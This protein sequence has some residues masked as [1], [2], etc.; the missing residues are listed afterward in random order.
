MESNRETGRAEHEFSA[1]NHQQRY[2]KTTKGR[3]KCQSIRRPLLQSKVPSITS[4][5]QFQS[6]MPSTSCPPCRK[7]LNAGGF[8]G[9]V[10]YGGSKRG[11][12]GGATGDVYM[13]F[14]KYFG[15]KCWNFKCLKFDD[16]NANNAETKAKR[17]LEFISSLLNENKS[18]Q[19]KLFERDEFGS[20]PI[21]FLIWVIQGIHSNL[22]HRGISCLYHSVRRI[23][24]C[25][26]LLPICTYVCMTCSVCARIKPP[27]GAH[28]VDSSLRSS[29]ANDVVHV[30]TLDLGVNARGTNY[31]YLQVR[32]DGWL[33]RIDAS[34]LKA[35]DD[36]ASRDVFIRD[37]IN[38]YG[39]CRT[40]QTD[41]GTEF[42]GTFDNMLRS[43]NIKHH[44]T[45]VGSSHSHGIAE[46]ANREILQALRAELMERGLEDC[47]WHLVL[48]FVLSK[49]KLSCTS[50]GG[51]SVF[52]KVNGS[53]PM[54]NCASI[55]YSFFDA[56]PNNND[57]DN[58]I[59]YEV[60]E[61][62]LFFHP[63]WQFGHANSRGMKLNGVWE[64]M[65]IERKLSRH[66][67][68]I[69]AHP[70]NAFRLPSYR[71]VVRV[72]QLRKYVDNNLNPIANPPPLAQPI[73][74]NNPNIDGFSVGSLVIFKHDVNES[75]RIGKLISVDRTNKMCNVHLFG[76]YLKGKGK[77]INKC[78]YPAWCHP[79]D[80]S[81]CIFKNESPPSFVPFM[82]SISINDIL[83]HGFTLLPNGKL[84]RGLVNRYMHG[85]EG[86]SFFASPFSI[87][88]LEGEEWIDAEVN[89]HKVEKEMFNENNLHADRI[90]TDVRNSCLSA[91][92]G[93]TSVFTPRMMDEDDKV[94]FNKAIENEFKSFEEKKVYRRL[95]LDSVDMNSIKPIR[96]KWVFTRKVLNVNNKLNKIEYKYKARLTARGDMDKREDVDSS[97]A[98]PPISSL[99][100]I[101][102]YATSCLV[103]FSP[104]DL[105]QA[106]VNTAYLNASLD[107]PTPVYVW[108]PREHPDYGKYVWILD[109]AMYGMREAG[110]KWFNHLWLN[111]LRPVG[112]E[113]TIFDGLYVRYTEDRKIDGV[114]FAWVDDLFAVSGRTKSIDLL[115]EIGKFVD[116]K[117]NGIPRNFIGLNIDVSKSR[118]LLSQRD[119]CKRIPVFEYKCH[120]IP[121]SPLPRNIHLDGNKD[122]PLLDDEY[123]F[124]YRSLWGTV[125]FLQHSRPDLNYCISFFGRFISK[126]TQYAWR[127]LLR[128]AYYCKHTCNICIE[129]KVKFTECLYI[130]A[131]CDA[132]FGSSDHA[133]A[134]T[135][136]LI[137]VNKSPVIFKSGLQRRVATSTVKAELSALHDCCDLLLLLIYFFSQLNVNVRVNLYSDAKNL[138]SLL[139]AAHP[140]PAEKYLLI[141]LR[142][143]QEILDGPKGNRIPRLKNRSEKRLEKELN[144]SVIHTLAL[145]DMFTYLPDY[146]I[147][148]DHI[149]GTINP[150][151][152]LTKSV[153]PS[154]MLDNFLVSAGM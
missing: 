107:S 103:D 1:T 33:S 98:T 148:L 118:V 11:K 5:N 133:H 131:Y 7:R 88:C 23:L 28:R 97:S 21:S 54:F 24:Y 8:T 152:V 99:R 75:L 122:S 111:V 72:N 90:Y 34:I 149:S 126:P 108:P 143:I 52:E 20:A 129:F 113:M 144:D 105:Q 130:D 14:D 48:P 59:S 104:D 76:A 94:G 151:D 127:L 121:D 51:P 132:S 139:K 6:P 57:S 154:V 92:V 95:P 55:L 4:P 9:C 19:F 26:Y 15:S 44:V 78:F 17:Y 46:R 18:L 74:M 29:A 64:D 41:G 22:A 146:N 56:I 84:P 73:N 25:D 60:G 70:C 102:S 80:S 140:K 120:K 138:V 35:H 71:V 32:T 43:F 119:Y 40:C 153:D 147:N 115:R 125:A 110:N 142:K 65:I 89:F 39:T 27:F 62:V 112:Y 61:R 50:V 36:D 53:P 117:Y 91:I 45:P 77:L 101:I 66:V 68:V 106:D 141:E 13:S 87:D 128:C 123:I 135:G 82:L 100:A 2:R 124:H 116:L 31:R 63:H 30:D 83:A 109:R 81:R 67:Y 37:H 150:A 96:T 47:D 93:S 10:F 137:C 49:L 85:N 79:L 145:V 114:M 134:Q 69:R 3:G 16:L 58:S 136:Y 38:I 12:E 42:M 86:Y